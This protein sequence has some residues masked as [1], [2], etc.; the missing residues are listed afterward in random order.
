MII[1]KD[2]LQNFKVV[3]KIDYNKLS[4][5]KEKENKV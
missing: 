3:R 1:W 2:D 5:W 4:N